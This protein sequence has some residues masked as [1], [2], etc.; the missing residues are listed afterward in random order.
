VCGRGKC[1]ARPQCLDIRRR[2]RRGCLVRAGSGWALADVSVSPSSGWMDVRAYHG[3]TSSS[4]VKPYEDPRTLP[5][6]LPLSLTALFSL[7]SCLASSVSAGYLPPCALFRL[8]AQVHELRAKHPLRA[9][10]R[11][12]PKQTSL[13]CCARL[14]NDLDSS[15]HRAHGPS[16][17]REP[18]VR[19]MVGAVDWL[20]TCAQ[21]T[22]SSRSPRW[23]S[24][25]Q[26]EL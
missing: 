21:P 26:R 6:A 14:Q 16:S 25:S 18:T 20:L 23:P 1:A 2:R 7:S 3:T 24:P 19:S 11:P 5:V 15:H 4:Q 22:L 13:D 8:C 10:I 17:R 9:A 12:S